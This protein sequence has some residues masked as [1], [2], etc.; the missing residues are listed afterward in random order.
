[1]LFIE[2]EILLSTVHQW[3]IISPR[4]SLATDKQTFM[5]LVGSGNIS[6]TDLVSISQNQNVA[7]DKLILLLQGFGLIFQHHV[8]ASEARQFFIPCF[9]S[10][11]A[12]SDI[13]KE[14]GYDGCL[15]VLFKNPV[16]VS[17]MLFYQLCFGLD[18][19]KDT[20]DL[21]FPGSNCCRCQYLGV[22][23]ELVHQKLMDRIQIR[24]NK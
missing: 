4:T 10:E 19:L 16:H 3:H 6:Y 15:Y 14:E 1:M 21:D 22:D 11:V 23:M 7:I 17:S 18:A 9:L 5:K 12:P 13:Q 20:K 2:P 8:A 24:L